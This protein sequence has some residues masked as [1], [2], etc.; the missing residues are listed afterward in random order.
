MGANR[1]L[2]IPDLRAPILN[3]AQRQ[4][5]AEAER[6]PFDLSLDGVLA[7]AVEKTGLDDFGPGDF[8]ERLALLVDVVRWDGHTRLTQLSTFRR[9]VSKATDRLLTIDLLKRHPEIAREKIEAPLVVAG[10]PRSGT[11]HLLNLIAADSRFQ[12]LPYWQ[13]LRPVPLMPEDAVGP[14]GV[15]PR[16]RR[17]D[18]AW[19]ELQRLNPY[20]AAHHPMDPDHISEDGELQMADFSSYVWEFS[21]HAPAWRDYYLAHDQTPHYRY[22]RSMLQVLQWQRGQAK[23][24]IIKAPQ[25]FEQLRPIM[26]VFPDAFVIFTHRDPVASL[27]SIIT[28]QAYTARWRRKSVDLDSIL[29]YWTERYGRLLD[30]YLRDVA[31]VPRDQRFD[32]LFHEFV[33]NDLATIEQLYQ[34]L[35]IEMTDQA[36]AQLER[37]MR[38]H[39]RGAQGQLVHDLRADFDANPAALR[40][41]YRSYVDRIPVSIEVR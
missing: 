20:A 38:R 18:A 11:T 15:D 40:D 7:A 6:T 28:M 1:R 9:M 16:W 21:L 10:L 4:A 3:R 24:W 34:V 31:V 37:Y 5:L 27:Q 36:R 12:S 33:G 26:T 39:Y 22:E 14:D 25:H 41:R 13:V 19:T 30:A 8:R 23:R 2:R 17:A 29:N 35:R 32:I